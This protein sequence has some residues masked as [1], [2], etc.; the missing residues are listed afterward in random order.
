MDTAY[1]RLDQII[2]LCHEFEVL[3]APPRTDFQTSY[4]QAHCHPV[5]CFPS[6]CR[7]FQ[8]PA[9]EI[10]LQ[11]DICVS[12]EDITSSWTYSVENHRERQTFFAR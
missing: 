12:V 1:A 7:G 4:R 5:Y 6:C 2:R 8:C 9:P 10:V 11:T 3:H